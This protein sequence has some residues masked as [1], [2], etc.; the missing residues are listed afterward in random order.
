M[1]LANR[2]DQQ[3]WAAI[4]VS[5]R[6]ICC[7]NAIHVPRGYADLPYAF[8]AARSS[9]PGGELDFARPRLILDYCPPACTFFT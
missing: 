6:K 8:F 2:P 5:R 7:P 9:G 1:A 3:P 4:S